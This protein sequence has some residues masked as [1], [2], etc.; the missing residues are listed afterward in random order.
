MIH[1]KIC[2][3]DTDFFATSI[4]ANDFSIQAQL[5]SHIAPFTYS[6]T[7]SERRSFA[8]RYNKDA[9]HLGLKYPIWVTGLW[10][11]R[12]KI[13]ASPTNRL[14]FMSSTTVA[15]YILSGSTILHGEPSHFTTCFCFFALSLAL[16][17][18][19]M[20]K[21]FWTL[22]CCLVDFFPSQLVWGW[23]QNRNRHQKSGDVSKPQSVPIHCL[24][25]KPRIAAELAET[26][27]TS[28]VLGMSS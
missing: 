16:A 14:A 10:T 22:Q 23:F 2:V 28:L 21:Q 27:I 11:A 1:L 18:W 8:F 20:L 19:G 17:P 9:F 6:H 26:V 5:H 24:D 7:F 25:T 13:V 3:S 12:S 4:T 15:K